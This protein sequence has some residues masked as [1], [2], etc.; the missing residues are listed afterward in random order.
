MT[1]PTAGRG[2]PGVVRRRDRLAQ[3]GA[4]DARGAPR[5]R[6][7]RRL[8]DLHLRQLAADAALRPRL[9]RRSTREPG[10]DRRSASTRP[11]SGSSTTSTTSSRSRAAFGV[12]Y[13]IAVDSDYGVW[14][15]FANHFWPAIYLADAQGRIR[16][17]HFGEGEYAMTEMAIQ[18]LLLDAGADDVDQDLVSVDP[19]GLEVAAD[20]RSLR[21][22][23]TY[24]GY[25]QATGF[26]S[27]DGLREDQPHDYDRAGE[28]PPQLTGRRP[29]R[30]RSPTARLC[31]TEPGG[32]IAF[33][34][35]A[36]DVN[37]VMGPA[38]GR[39]A[40]P[41]PR[42]PRRPAG[43]RRARIRRRRRRHRHGRPSSAPTSS[44]ASRARSPSAPSRSSS[45]TPASR[46]TASPSA[47]R[48]H[49][50]EP[51]AGVRAPISCRAEERTGA[52]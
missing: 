46:R 24:L 13:P 47:E 3:L 33:R 4:A 6:R 32:R 11:S 17:H 16:Y 49:E 15:A 30:G 42:P 37:L 9:G 34:F 20:Y 14:R 25:G 28:L 44:S 31:S 52:S 27:P 40:D 39:H 1:P 21:S 50:G 23:E 41:V 51:S 8:L 5:A 29:E 12:D 19:R 48:R 35:Q 36:R 43:R 38:P 45:S 26:A 22:P 2:P 7:P 18:Q 10:A